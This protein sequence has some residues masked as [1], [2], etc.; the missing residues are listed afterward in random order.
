MGREERG[1]DQ[2]GIGLLL[3]GTRS[4]VER[5]AA[6]ATVAP[7][8]FARVRIHGT[9]RDLPLKLVDDSQADSSVTCETRVTE[10]CTPMDLRCE[11]GSVSHSL[12]HR[13]M[14][15]IR[16][17]AL[18]LI[19][20]HAGVAHALIACDWQDHHSQ[21]ASIQTHSHQA[22]TEDESAPLVAPCGSPIFYALLPQ[23]SA[24]LI[25]PL[26]PG[27]SPPWFAESHD[28]AGAPPLTRPDRPP[29][30][31]MSVSSSGFLSFVSVFRI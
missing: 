6:L 7:S 16:V 23:P 26:F 21:I 20:L 8:V 19:F 1:D 25:E 30:M 13:Q 24:P 31:S 2:L 10:D 18:S 4:R 27:E 14:A 5:H 11:F 22:N 29:S 3:R 9:D 12:K 28:A 15:R 17:I